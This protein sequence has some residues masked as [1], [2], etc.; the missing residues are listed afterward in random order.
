M[1]QWKLWVVAL[2]GWAMAATAV[3]ADDRPDARNWQDVLREAR[4][5]IVYWHAWA[6][7]PSINSYIDWAGSVVEDRYG[8]SVVHVKLSDTAEAVAKVIAEKAA[9][10]GRGGSVDLMWIN[11]ANFASLKSKNLLFGPWAEHLP[12]RAL[13]DSAARVSLDADFTV[14]VEG[15]ESPWDMAQLVFFFDSARVTDPPRTI[16]DFLAYAR[17]HPGRVTM[18]DA[19][20][21]LGVTFLK[22]ALFELTSERDALQHPAN[23]ADFKRITSP[24]WSFLDEIRPY[25]WRRGE[26]YPSNSAELRQ[27]LADREIDIAFSF[28]PSEAALAIARK[29]L[30]STVSAYVLD[31]GTIANASFVAIPFNAA[32]KAGAMVLAD[33]LLSPEA[34][35]RKLDPQV[36][37]GLTVLDVEALSPKDRA[38]FESVNALAA[39]LPG[40]KLG[41]VI[42]EPH[43][44]WAT[45]IAEE[46]IERYASQ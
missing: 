12:N 39:K 1:G 21:F 15:F 27:L 20:N 45:R 3:S 25:L 46:W 5:Q 22:Q 6:G 40:R 32:H 36:W 38:R 37:G 33:F 16:R 26:A 42:P 23:D 14:P 31:G 41:P 43:P 44:T 30:P 2:V 4:G 29:E 7:E 10:R 35:A 28:N 18:P 34:Q 13:V 11:G 17:A 9:G 8:V 24:L 19:Q